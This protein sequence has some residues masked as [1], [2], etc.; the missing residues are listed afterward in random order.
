MKN[1]CNL[2]LSTLE[3]SV[4]GNKRKCYSSNNI[5]VQ[6]KYETFV[7]FITDKMKQMP[8]NVANDKRIFNN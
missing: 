6:D 7:K 3:K 8:E 2:Y 4:P 1:C 5:L